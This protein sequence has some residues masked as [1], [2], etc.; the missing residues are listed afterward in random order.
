MDAKAMAEENEDIKDKPN[1]ED[2]EVMNLSK[3]KVVEVKVAEV[4]VVEAT[5]AKASEI[6]VPAD[7]DSP[8]RVDRR[9][10]NC[11]EKVKSPKF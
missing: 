10:V 8:S 9:R 5:V 1:A 6:E 2:T 4:E 3:A 11:P 7:A